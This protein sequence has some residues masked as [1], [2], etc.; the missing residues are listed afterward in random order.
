MKS[1]SSN[2][3]GTWTDD[4]LLFPFQSFNQTLDLISSPKVKN[5]EDDFGWGVVINFRKKA[6]QSSA[7]PKDGPLYI[8]EILLNCSKESIKNAV[9]EAARPAKEGQ[10]GEMA[11]RIENKMEGK[12]KREKQPAELPF[13]TGLL[14]AW[15]TFCK[16]E[17]FD[18]LN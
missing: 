10:R 3:F 2:K 8:A 9:T 11:V 16:G 15:K 12:C 1:E 6:N 14:N 7:S 5:E 4:C 18:C 17:R 13:R